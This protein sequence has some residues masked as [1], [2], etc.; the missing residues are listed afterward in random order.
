[1]EAK[2]E[3]QLLIR[4]RAFAAFATTEKTLA[5]RKKNPR[6]PYVLRACPRLIHLWSPLSYCYEEKVEK[7]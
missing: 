4:G 1:L 5:G 7:R 3:R 2:L 6:G